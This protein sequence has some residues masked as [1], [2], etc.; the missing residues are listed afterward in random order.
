MR[1][2]SSSGIGAAGENRPS[3]FRGDFRCGGL[4]SRKVPRDDRNLGALFGQ[5]GRNRFADAA[6][7]AGNDRDPIRLVPDPLPLLPAR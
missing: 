2:S 3:G 7:A 5:L 4:G 6:A 1:T